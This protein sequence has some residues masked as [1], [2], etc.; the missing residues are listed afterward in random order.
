MQGRNR[1]DE[2]TLVSFTCID[3]GYTYRLSSL[4]ADGSFS[5]KLPPGTYTISANRQQYLSAVQTI[6]L[7]SAGNSSGLNLELKAGDIDGNGRIDPADLTLFFLA[8]LHSG[9]HNYNALAD[10][11]GN[12]L[13]DI[14]DLA[15]LARNYGAMEDI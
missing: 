5:L 11:N 9:N 13:V 15:I 14:I 1:T 2:K 3:S 10:L 12:G 8:Y 7:T 4:S 6:D